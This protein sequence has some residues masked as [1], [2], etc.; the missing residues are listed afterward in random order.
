VPFLDG[1]LVVAV[2]MALFAIIE[3][4]KQIRLQLGAAN[5]HGSQALHAKR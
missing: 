3:T 4:E 2:G 5:T 1:L